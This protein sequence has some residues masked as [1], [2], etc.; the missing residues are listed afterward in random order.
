MRAP[1]HPV[2]R[3]A[4]LFLPVC[5]FDYQRAGD[6]VAEKKTINKNSPPFLSTNNDD[7]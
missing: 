6:N 1:T 7:E 5:S 4:K 2:I 3:C